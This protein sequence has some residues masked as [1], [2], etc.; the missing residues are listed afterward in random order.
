MGPLG[1]LLP[2]QLWIR[3]LHTGYPPLGPLFRYTRASSRTHSHPQADALRIHGTF[4]HVDHVDLLHPTASFE[5]GGTGL[6]TRARKLLLEYFGCGGFGDSHSI[7]FG[8]VGAHKNISFVCL[9]AAWIN[10][11]ITRDS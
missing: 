10:Y 1:C 7:L 6:S 4:L 5:L 11:S 8:T 2:V 9:R 3:M